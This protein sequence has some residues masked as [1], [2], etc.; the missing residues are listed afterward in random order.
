[1]HEPYRIRPQLV[2]LERS[3]LTQ[4]YHLVLKLSTYGRTRLSLTSSLLTP[5][6]C[7][8][9]KRQETRTDSGGTVRTIEIP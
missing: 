4:D 7:S 9:R 5:T 3:S 8:I 2:K 6:P 1:M